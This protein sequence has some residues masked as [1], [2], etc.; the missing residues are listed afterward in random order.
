M[1]N[2]EL[3]SF[4]SGSDPSEVCHLELNHSLRSGIVAIIS[5]ELILCTVYSLKKQKYPSGLFLFRG[6]RGIFSK[7]NRQLLFN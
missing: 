5:D 1:I 7:I 6:L 4:D 2:H 3:V